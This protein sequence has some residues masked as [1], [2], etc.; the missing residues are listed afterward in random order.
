M[1]N[2]KRVFILMIPT[3]LCGRGYYF[4]SEM[5]STQ[6]KT[7]MLTLKRVN[8]CESLIPS[9][10]IKTDSITPKKSILDHINETGLFSVLSA[11]DIPNKEFPATYT[12]NINKDLLDRV[13]RHEII[14]MDSNEIRFWRFD[15]ELHSENSNIPRNIQFEVHEVKENLFQISIQ[16]SNHE[17]PVIQLFQDE[18]YLK[19]IQQYNIPLLK[20]IAKDFPPYFSQGANHK[21]YKIVLPTL[22]ESWLLRVRADQRGFGLTFSPYKE[23]IRAAETLKIAESTSLFINTLIAVVYHPEVASFSLLLRKIPNACTIYHY[24]SQFTDKDER[25]KWL[26]TFLKQGNLIGKKLF[27]VRIDFDAIGDNNIIVNKEEGQI[28]FVDLEVRYSFLSTK[29]ELEYLEDIKHYIL[30]HSKFER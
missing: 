16:N 6:F 22:N 3:T 19:I 26:E 12:D 9:K 25:E 23:I 27:S 20:Y 29:N 10:K 24:L 11:K 18:K 7:K 28:Y 17:V 14:L 4:S 2:I 30:D 1:I 15:N 8:S 21:L 5:V 13:L